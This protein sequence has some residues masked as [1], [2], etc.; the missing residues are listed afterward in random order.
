MTKQTNNQKQ[1][2]IRKT[3]KKLQKGTK[4]TMKSTGFKKKLD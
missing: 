3:N 1:V 4:R 2:Q